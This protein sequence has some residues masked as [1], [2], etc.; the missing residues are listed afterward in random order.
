MCM[1]V[2]VCICVY[3]CG[4]GGHSIW[5]DPS[6]IHTLYQPNHIISINYYWQLKYAISLHM[7]QTLPK[8]LHVLAWG[9]SRLRAPYPVKPL[10]LL[11][12]YNVPLNYEGSQSWLM[13]NWLPHPA[14]WWISSLLTCCRLLRAC[15]CVVLV[16]VF[17]HMRRRERERD[18]DRGNHF[19]HCNMRRGANQKTARVQ[20]TDAASRC[21]NMSGPLDHSALCVLFASLYL[22]TPAHLH[23]GRWCNI[24][25]V[26][27]SVEKNRIFNARS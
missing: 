16:C 19:A 2:G 20:A 11:I 5:L 18:R 12:F 23:H 26:Q 25:K 1:C 8:V 21:W 4:G 14:H 7:M 27:S 6:L 3:V 9:W 24:N 13:F 22:H 10:E 15:V 17:V